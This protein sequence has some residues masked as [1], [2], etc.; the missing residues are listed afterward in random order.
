[1]ADINPALM[2][3][4]GQTQY[5]PPAN[6]PGAAPIPSRTGAASPG[7]AGAILDMIRALSQSFAPRA[8]TGHPSATQGAIDA[9]SQGNP[10]P[11]LGEQLAGRQ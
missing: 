1:M 11:G 8:I 6:A 7:F 9:Q 2:P 5:V 4:Q 10:A 3:Q